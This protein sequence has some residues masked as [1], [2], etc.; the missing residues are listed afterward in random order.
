M[1]TTTETNYAVEGEPGVYWCA[2]HKK[3]K[4]RLRC[5]RCEKP[6]CPKCTIMGP[7]GARC[8]DCA[9]NRTS[10]MYQ[11][12]PGQYL[13]SF[14]AAMLISAV[15]AAILPVLGGLVFWA[16]IYA[17]VL[18]PMMGKVITLI[19]RGKR[20]P[21]LATVVSLGIVCGSVLAF[22][23]SIMVRWS[24][25]AQAAGATPGAQVPTSALAYLLA[26]PYQLAYLFIYTA[27][28]IGGV[29]WWLK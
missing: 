24:L 27:V 19:T 2:R 10:H 17:P 15:G 6:I 9:S 29:W 28:A 7:T 20:G 22:G 12:K 21:K 23:I 1:T 25:M 18:G 16:L 8:P 13:L 5:G 26:D 14:V 4:T 3:V 11:V